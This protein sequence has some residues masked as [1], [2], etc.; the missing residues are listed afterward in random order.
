MYPLNLQWKVYLVIAREYD[1][2][3][4][5]FICNIFLAL[6]LWKLGLH[7]LLSHLV[8]GIAYS[9]SFSLSYTSKWLDNMADSENKDLKLLLKKKI[10]TFPS[11]EKPPGI[12]V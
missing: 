6:C 11:N 2:E 12:Y 1:F 10:F 4:I 9:N 5:N 7:K 3:L 8:S